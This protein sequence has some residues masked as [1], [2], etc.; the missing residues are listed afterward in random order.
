MRTRDAALCLLLGVFAT[1]CASSIDRTIRAEWTGDRSA[2]TSIPM[3][4]LPSNHIYVP[5]V[6]NGRE[7]ELLVDTGAAITVLDIAFARKL[8]L[9]RVGGVTVSGVG[10]TE[11]G[12]YVRVRSIRVG[13]LILRNVLAIAINLSPIARRID[14]DIPV[15][16]GKGF[17]DNA[18]VEVDYPRSRFVCHRRAGFHYDGPGRT[19]R[20]QTARSGLKNVRCQIESLAPAWFQ[21]D[22]GSGKSISVFEKYT[23]RNALLEGRKPRSTR[24]GGGVGGFATESVASLRSFT[25]AGYPLQDVPANFPTPSGGAFVNKRHAGNLGGG[26]LRR[27]HLWIDFKANEM[28]VEPGP[29]IESPFDRDRLGLVTLVRGSALVVTHI[30][31]GSPAQK[32]G[33]KKGAKLVRIENQQAPPNRLRQ[34]L[35]DAARGPDGATVRLRDGDGNDYRITLATHYKP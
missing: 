8:R 35:R 14:H 30:S 6:V 20:L 24:V 28:H 31:P 23:T 18:V 29:L 32:S 10:G 27:F 1:S 15:I 21:L 11:S 33:I 25:F 17:F 34:L 19:V 2:P 7:T 4:V 16:L 13:D 9:K 3:D 26:I 12:R 5:G 22:T